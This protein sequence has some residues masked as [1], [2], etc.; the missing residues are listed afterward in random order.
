MNINCEHEYV[1]IAKRV[2]EIEKI[3]QSDIIQNVDIR[4]LQ[5]ILEYIASKLRS[6]TTSKNYI[7]RWEYTYD[8]TEKLIKRLTKK[9]NNNFFETR[10]IKCSTCSL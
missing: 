4:R 6:N 5:E 10:P 2:S 8:Y 9:R 3:E 7:W 1:G